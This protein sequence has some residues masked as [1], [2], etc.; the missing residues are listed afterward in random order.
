M[1]ARQEN[2]ENVISKVGS[3][4]EAG[5]S[6]INNTIEWQLRRKSEGD[7]ND[8][9][10]K[11]KV[12]EALNRLHAEII[13][14]QGLC[15]SLSSQFSEWRQ[16][17][18]E[19]LRTSRDSR[20]EELARKLEQRNNTLEDREVDLRGLMNAFSS[21]MSQVWG[22]LTGN[23]DNANDA[24]Q[25][26]IDQLQERFD[27]SLMRE[28]TW[29][30][31]NLGQTEAAVH[32]LKEHVKSLI[33]AEHG[34]I[35][36]PGLRDAEKLRLMLRQEKGT[37]ARLT[38]NIQ[39]LEKEA[40]LMTGLRERWTRD[41]RL[42]DSL[43]SQL[44]AIQ[45]RMP[46]V[47]G[48]AA[49]LDNIGRLNAFI[50]STASYPSDE[51][52]WIQGELKSRNT[53]E[54]AASQAAESSQ[55]EGEASQSA[56][57][58]TDADNDPTVSRYEFASRRVMVCSPAPELDPPSPPLSIE[59]EQIRRREGAKPR[60]ILRVTTAPTENAR[61]REVEEL[62]I[63]FSYSQYNR[64]VMAGSSKAAEEPASNAKRTPAVSMDDI[65]RIGKRFKS[66]S[67]ESSP[68]DLTRPGKTSGTAQGRASAG[69]KGSRRVIRT[70]SRKPVEE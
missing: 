15:Q 70:Y 38:K 16:N 69:T 17:E 33:Q 37:V 44:S 26:T 65:H 28:R 57:T 25:E 30:A 4:F 18:T 55:G 24:L 62:G 27:A 58:E 64:P 43:R 9:C 68:G 63:S 47:E 56:M 1:S 53:D 32:E 59:Q 5:L 48:M 2:L 45:Q 11:G 3:V 7:V 42:I 6:G 50:H 31:Q 49:K 52:K 19:A 36:A 22:K 39:K 46:R 21:K 20:Q 34:A 10:G 40:A 35:E 60:P 51:K 66:D 41:L 29:S 23:R 61:A 13:G 8:E 54:D 14:T 67:Q 12:M